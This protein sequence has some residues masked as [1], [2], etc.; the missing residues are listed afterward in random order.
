[1][2]NS[3]ICNLKVK[4]LDFGANRVTILPGKNHKDRIIHISA[5][6]TNVSIEYLEKIKHNR[7]DYLFSTVLKKNKLHPSDL[8][9]ILRTVATRQLGVRRVY[10]H[11]IQCGL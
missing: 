9:K 1:M 3:E 6:C 7:D 11:L 5:E 10:P 4:G 8:R 2:R